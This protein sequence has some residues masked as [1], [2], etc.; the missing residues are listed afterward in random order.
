[1]DGLSVIGTANSA[2]RAL[3]QLPGSVPDILLTDVQVPGMDGAD[4][5]SQVRKRFPDVRICALSMSG[6]RETIGRLLDAGVSGYLLKN[7]G[8][9]ELVRAIRTIAGGSCIF[10]ER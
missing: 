2:E 4:L 3:E 6:D 5:T 7:S 10:P 1:V 9:E 8:Q